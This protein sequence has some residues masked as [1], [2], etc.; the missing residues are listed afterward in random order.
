MVVL[1]WTPALGVTQIRVKAMERD[2]NPAMRQVKR[3]EKVKNQHLGATRKE[4]GMQG[5]E[6][7]FVL[8]GSEFAMNAE[9]WF[10]L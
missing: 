10:T 8:Q 4:L 3:R 7:E 2:R 5:T 1:Q 9:A 6:K